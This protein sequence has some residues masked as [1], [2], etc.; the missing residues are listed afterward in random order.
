[1]LW[2]TLKMPCFVV[3]IENGRAEGPE[4]QRGETTFPRADI[5]IYNNLVSSRIA[6]QLINWLV[7]LTQENSLQIAGF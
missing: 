4:S 1:M 2:H 6:V 3:K 7:A 5:E